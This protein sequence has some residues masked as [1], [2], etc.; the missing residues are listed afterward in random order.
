MKRRLPPPLLAVSPGDLAA[1]VVPGFLA[2]LRAAVH[3]GLSGIVLREPAMGD[4]VLLELAREAREMLP[5]DAWLGIHDRVHLADAAR[6]DAVHLGFR[7]LTP[8]EARRILPDGIAIGFSAHEGDDLAHL[9]ACD[10]VLFGPVF[11]TPSKRGWKDPVGLTGL[12]RAVD[13]CAVP[14]WAIGGLQPEHAAA[15]ALAGCAGIAARAGIFAAADPARA[16]GDYR[17]A[18]ETS[19]A[20]KGTRDRA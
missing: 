6:A 3:G 18:V 4:R 11:D 16:T 15:C 7:S 8:L 14:V 12:A 10:Y 5:E 13:V 17:A 20:P 2:K 9:A 1:P 19:F